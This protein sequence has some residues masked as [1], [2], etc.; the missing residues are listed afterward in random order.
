MENISNMKRRLTIVAWIMGVL[1]IALSGTLIGV[2]AASNQGLG[3]NFSIS[4][5][6]GQNVAMKF[7]YKVN[8]ESQTIYSTSSFSETYQQ[9]ED[10]YVTFDTGMETATPY[11]KN[12]EIDDALNLTPENLNITFEF[13][14]INISTAPMYVMWGEGDIGNYNWLFLFDMYIKGVGESP[15]EWQ[16]IAQGAEAIEANQI[17]VGSNGQSDSHLSIKLVVYPHDTTWTYEE[18]LFYCSMIVTSEL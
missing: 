7:R 12:S 5:D 10:G 1:I 15:N 17:M 4:Y 16:Q 2:L 8:D 14:F 11:F 6:I 3:S 18:E 13:D 9:D